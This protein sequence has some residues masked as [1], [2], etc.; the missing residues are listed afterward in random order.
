LPIVDAPSDVL[1]ALRDDA[2]SDSRNAPLCTLSSARAGISRFRGE[3][4]RRVFETRPTPLHE[5]DIDIDIEAVEERSQEVPLESAP[6]PPSALDALPPLPT[7]PWLRELASSPRSRADLL[8][9]NI[10]DDIVKDVRGSE[11]NCEHDSRK[12]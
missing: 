8:R 11:S 9:A 1:V 2:L 5:P 7:L 4:P 10:F 6:P 3:P 12:M